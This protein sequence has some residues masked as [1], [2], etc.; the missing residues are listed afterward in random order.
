MPFSDLWMGKGSS[1]TQWNCVDDF[2]K[3]NALV[4]VAPFAWGCKLSLFGQVKCGC[5]PQVLVDSVSIVLAS[6][7]VQA[8]LS[9][10]GFNGL[11]GFNAPIRF[12]MNGLRH[13][14]EGKDVLVLELWQFR[15]HL[16]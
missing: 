5:L 13:I 8:A 16:K 15:V 11:H 6:S 3:T 1:E 4:A 9:G 7:S 12:E 2:T 14:L 10:D